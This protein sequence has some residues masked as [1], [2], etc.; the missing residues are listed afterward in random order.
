M[1][2]K[3]LL[4]ILFSLFCFQNNS[5]QK[6]KKRVITGVVLKVDK[7]PIANAII[8]IDNVKTNSIT[9]AEGKYKVKVKPEALKIGVVTFGNGMREEDISGRTR[10][11]FNFSTAAPG[12]P[13][14]TDIPVSEEAVNSGYKVDK[15]KFVTTEVSK[16]DGSDKKFASYS[17]IYDMIQRE[18]SGVQVHGTSIIIQQSKNLWG[19]VGPLLIVDGVTVNSIEDVRPSAVNSIEVLKGTSAAIYGTRGYGGVIIITTKSGNK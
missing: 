8:M 12:P 5:A 1:K 7:S 14:E 13:V 19:Y 11:D 9:N 15:R 4:I 2:S 3:L 18:V 17:T 6:S 16:I 10:I